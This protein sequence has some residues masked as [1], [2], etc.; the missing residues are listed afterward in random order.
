MVACPL[1]FA[2]GLYLFITGR[3]G[4]LIDDHPLCKR[5][6]FD[7]TGKA[8]DNTLCPE[9]GHDVSQP[10][11]IRH[12]N[13]KRS[14]A[15][16]VVGSVMLLL[17][18][19]LAV[20]V[21][22]TLYNNVN[23]FGFLPTWYLRDQVNTD[24]KWAGKSWREFNS[25]YFRK[26]LNQTQIKQITKDALAFQADG[27]RPWIADAGRWIEKVH[28]DGKLSTEDWYKYLAVIAETYAISSKVTIRPKIPHGQPI[29]LNYDQRGTYR[30][31]DM[32]MRCNAA[33]RLVKIGDVPTEIQTFEG[34][35]QFNYIA[36]QST[37][38]PESLKSE[39]WASI[40]PGTYDALFTMKMQFCTQS[41][42]EEQ[43]YGIFK[44]DSPDVI[45]KNVSYNMPVTILPA[46]RTDVRPVTDASL[47]DAVEAA[48]I[49]NS[50]KF[51]PS[52]GEVKCSIQLHHSPVAVAFDAYVKIKGTEYKID[53][54][55]ARSNCRYRC[56]LD[57]R[58]KTLI[59]Q[60][61][62]V[63]DLI[64]KPS[65]KEAEST[66]EITEYWGLP[67]VFENVPVLMIE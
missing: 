25:R 33:G 34:V 59:G 51:K 35:Y 50:I 36:G 66:V 1:L 45:V 40:K 55:R 26:K 47:K 43:G 42:Y 24:T 14:P 27:K 30:F 11:Q 3:R 4:R 5:C 19:L 49:L 65:A 31:G 60:S 6:R 46:Q 23:W 38:M 20:L 61:V 22:A 15:R 17:A 12:G 2:L 29:P 32:V 62:T 28:D 41:V 48:L 56:S 52:N 18:M 58:I 39:T 44:T 10:K 21:S 67:V 37:R 53:N 8:K 9:C 16:T 54:L 63:A 64:L 7:L 13:R 57:D